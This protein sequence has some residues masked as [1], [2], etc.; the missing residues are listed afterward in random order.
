[1]SISYGKSYLSFV[2]NEIQIL[3]YVEITLVVGEKL[4]SHDNV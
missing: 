1:M 3:K 2:L 4:K